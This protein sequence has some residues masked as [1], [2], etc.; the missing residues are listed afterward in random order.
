MR[1]RHASRPPARCLALLEHLSNYVDGD[2]APRQ[3]R[4]IERHCRDCARC[5]AM[6]AS[7]RRTVAVCRNCRGTGIPLRLRRRARARITRLLE[8]FAKS[9]AGPSPARWHWKRD[10]RR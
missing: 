3:R 9:Q 2:I 5:Q 1:A 10:G 8:E 4:M 7:L 6:V